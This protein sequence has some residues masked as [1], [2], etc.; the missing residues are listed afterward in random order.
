MYYSI[1]V[2]YLICIKTIR[3]IIFN[4]YSG[5]SAQPY[6]LLQVPFKKSFSDS[7]IDQDANGCPEKNEK[8]TLDSDISRDTAEQ[9]SSNCISSTEDMLTIDNAGSSNPLHAKSSE[10]LGHFPLRQK[11]LGELFKLE[12][13]SLVLS[14]KSQD[15]ADRDGEFLSS[16]VTPLHSSTKQGKGIFEDL[17]FPPLPTPDLSQILGR[18]PSRTTALPQLPSN[19]SLLNNSRGNLDEEG[20]SAQGTQKFVSLPSASELPMKPQP[21]STGHSLGTSQSRKKLVGQE[22]LPRV[23]C[24]KSNSKEKFIHAPREKYCPTGTCTIFLYLACN[25]NMN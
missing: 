9:S 10:Y 5:Y 4:W 8:S 2:H 13:R 11:E 3:V 23:A 18:S 22:S 6:E 17:Y 16:L 1:I 25:L 14:N 21:S 7:N 19:E 12:S 15:T 20:S 24:R